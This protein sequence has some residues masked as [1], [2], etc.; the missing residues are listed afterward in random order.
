MEKDLRR[1][2]EASETQGF[3]WDETKSGHPRVWKNGVFVT[4]FSKTP[5]DYRGH[6]NGIAAMRR[7]GFVWP[8]KR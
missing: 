4:T 7:A 5:S 2:K 8:P 1:V 3:T 6:R